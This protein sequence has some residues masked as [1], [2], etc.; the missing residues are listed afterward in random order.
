M[1]LLRVHFLLIIFSGLDFFLKFPSYWSEVAL[2]FDESKSLLHVCVLIIKLKDFPIFLSIL[3]IPFFWMTLIIAVHTIIILES[4]YV[5]M[6]TI[7][8]PHIQY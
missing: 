2:L 5:E 1:L 7:T 8:E 4:K 3:E 6:R